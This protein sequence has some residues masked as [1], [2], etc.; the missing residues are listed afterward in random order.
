MICCRF[1][2]EWKKLANAV[3]KFEVQQD[4]LR[5]NFAFS[6]VEGSLVEAV[7]NGHW[8]LLDEVNLATQETLEV[9]I[10]KH[11]MPALSAAWYCKSLRYVFR[12]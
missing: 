7:R 8:V 2:Q 10:S 6:F 11:I 9:H 12:V 4:Q 5:N 3:S 1:R